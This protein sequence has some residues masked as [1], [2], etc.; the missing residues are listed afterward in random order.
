MHDLF[1]SIVDDF[2]SLPAKVAAAQA[3]ASNLAGKQLTAR[4]LEIAQAIALGRTC[5]AI[6]FDLN[7][8]HRTVAEHRRRILEKM[9]IR[10]NAELAVWFER[11]AQP[12]LRQAL[13][14]LVAVV[15][16]IYERSEG[17]YPAA[18]I[19]CAVCTQGCAQA[20]DLCVLHRA[21]RLLAVKS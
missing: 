18:D 10:S 14:D 19:N 1:K 21:K 16:S 8:D 20:T 4:E 9:G 5:K 12:D 13:T 11:Q 7:I 17:L 6:G 2:T 3:K 15:E